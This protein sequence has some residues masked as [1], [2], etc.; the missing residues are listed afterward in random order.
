MESSGKRAG[1]YPLPNM[2]ALCALK[3]LAAFGP[4]FS[5]TVDA[6]QQ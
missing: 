3:G 2:A 1:E 6:A 4:D 5:V